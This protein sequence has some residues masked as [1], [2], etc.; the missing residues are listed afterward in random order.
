MV[1]TKPP[2][3][4]A[5]AGCWTR[6][7]QKKKKKRKKDTIRERCFTVLFISFSKGTPNVLGAVSVQDKVLSRTY[8]YYNVRHRR[9]RLFA[10]SAATATVCRL[11]QKKRFPRRSSSS[12][13]SYYVVYDGRLRILPM[14]WTTGISRL[15]ISALSSPPLVA[16]VQY[17]QTR[18]NFYG[19]AAGSRLDVLDW[20]LHC[21]QPWSRKRRRC[22]FHLFLAAIMPRRIVKA[23]CWFFFLRGMAASII[24]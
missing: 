21:N 19:V 23:S 3:M 7:C 9:L 17:L 4:P 6:V 20:G 12:Q 13:T 5:G 8:L 16:M 11:P 18:I 14:S 2:N 1:R 15:T 22:K 24:S 10:S